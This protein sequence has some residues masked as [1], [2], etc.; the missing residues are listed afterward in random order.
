MILCSLE[1]PTWKYFSASKSNE[2]VI[3]LISSSLLNTRPLFNILLLFVISEPMPQHSTLKNMMCSWII[4]LAILNLYYPG[5]IIIGVFYP[6]TK[7]KKKLIVPAFS[8]QDERTRSNKG[9]LKA[10]IAV[11]GWVHWLCILQDWILSVHKTAGKI[12]GKQCCKVN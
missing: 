12:P 6:A 2:P 8:V 1:K 7:K 10:K 11:A 9:F 5:E 4:D 3:P